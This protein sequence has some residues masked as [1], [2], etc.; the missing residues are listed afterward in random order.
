MTL[1]WID[2]PRSWQDSADDLIS[3]LREHPG[4]WARIARNTDG[5]VQHYTDYLESAGIEWRTAFSE[6]NGRGV[7]RKLDVYAR[8]PKEAE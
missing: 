1:E 8:H 7:G 5:L 4:R 6:Q 2:P 3:E